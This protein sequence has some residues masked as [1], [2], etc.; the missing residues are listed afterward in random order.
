M[1]AH[2]PQPFRVEVVTDRDAQR[3]FVVPHGELDIMTAG[4]LRAALTEAADHGASEVVL[5]MRRL[6]FIDSTGIR[7][8]VQTES[9]ARFNG[10]RFAI[11]EGGDPVARMLAMTGLSDQF[12]RHE[13]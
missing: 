6:T 4:E 12:R 7:L 5:D 1:P 10:G 13:G 8:L 2:V 11:I 3:V 9:A